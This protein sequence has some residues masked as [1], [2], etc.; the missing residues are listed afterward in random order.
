MLEIL[1]NGSLTEEQRGKY[2]P[3]EPCMFDQYEKL[4]GENVFMGNSTSAKVNGKGKIT[5]IL[6][7]GKF[8]TLI[9]VLHVPEMRRNLI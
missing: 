4:E 1:L 9:N 3:S 6:T 2:A 5:L 8:R 7:S